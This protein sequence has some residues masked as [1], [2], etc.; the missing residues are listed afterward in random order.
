MREDMK[1]PSTYF[2]IICLLALPF[3][4]IANACHTRDNKIKNDA[5]ANVFNIT[6]DISKE[7]LRRTI[8]TLVGFKTRYTWEKQE[9]VADYLF[10]SLTSFGIEAH[11]D[12]YHFNGKKYRNVVGTLKG[13]EKPEEAY[14][15]VAHY[16]SIS[17]TPELTAPGADDNASG[18]AVVLETARILSKCPPG[19][20][21]KFIFFSNEE[22]GLIGSKHY[23]S[24]ASEQQE[25]IL[26]VLNVDVVG[27]N[28]PEGP[29]WNPRGHSSIAGRLKSK[30]KYL[31]N[32]ALLKIH[33]G[34]LITV[35]GRSPNRRLV[36]TVGQHINRYSALYSDRKVSDDCG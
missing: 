28:N 13:K 25:T 20:S 14:L 8:N 12:T 6:S 7:N 29:L 4:L 34:G 35:A 11:F 5:L 22:Q 17:E 31:R 32:I 33:S 9:Q 10:R 21:V 24:F 1:R 3:N 16:D 15:L 18:I 19:L 23:A 27:F 2:L 30:I 36:N 26:G